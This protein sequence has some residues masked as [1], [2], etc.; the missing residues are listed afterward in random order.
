M[1]QAFLRL[2]KEHHEFEDSINY[3]EES[4]K[5]IHTNKQKKQKPKMHKVLGTFVTI[6]SRYVVI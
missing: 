1:S 3:I 5:N 4:L 2:N 6:I